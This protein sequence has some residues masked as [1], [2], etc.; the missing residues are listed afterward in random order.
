MARHGYPATAA[1]GRHEGSPKP[2]A[3]PGCFPQAALEDSKASLSQHG[4]QAAIYPP[5]YVFRR[6]ADTFL[7]KIRAHI[8]ERVRRAPHAHCLPQR[9]P[10]QPML[11]KNFCT[12]R[13]APGAGIR[14]RWQPAFPRCGSL[15]PGVTCPYRGHRECPALLLLHR[16][17][18]IPFHGGAIR[19]GILPETAHAAM[20]PSFLPAPDRVVSVHITACIRRSYGFSATGQRRPHLPAFR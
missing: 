18:R 19:Y 12:V 11:Q 2:P 15:A 13:T 6:V 8:P 5:Q 20:P 14:P 10:R 1:A 3:A 4:K 16:L 7:Y 17:W 9:T